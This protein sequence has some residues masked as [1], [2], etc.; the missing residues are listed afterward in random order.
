MYIPNGMSFSLTAIAKRKP[1]TRVTLHIIFWVCI[2]FYFAWGFGLAKNTR[3]GFLYSL[4]YLPGNLLMTYTLLYFLTP[5]YLVRKKY[6]HFFAGLA[7]LLI[8]CSCYAVFANMLMGVSLGNFKQTS[9]ETGK[10]VLPF[11]NV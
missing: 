3:E 1:V 6:V 8:I 5:V 9:V 11:V 7:L 2:V 10:N 4:L